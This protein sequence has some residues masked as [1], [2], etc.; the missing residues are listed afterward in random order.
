[1][2]LALMPF[3]N[4]ATEKLKQSKSS[5]DLLCAPV[6]C[7][8]KSSGENNRCTS[9]ESIRKEHMEEARYLEVSQVASLT[10]CNGSEHVKLIRPRTND[11]GHATTNAT[12]GIKHC[13]SNGMVHQAKKPGYWD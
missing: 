1:M 10:P 6:D 4:V 9:N 2:V 3:L 7:N 5:Y 8:S 11:A 12:K 13:L